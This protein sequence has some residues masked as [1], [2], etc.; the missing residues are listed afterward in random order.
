MVKLSVILPVFNEEK[1]I[2]LLYDRLKN[3]MTTMQADYEFIFINDGSSDN[4]LQHVKSLSEKD[5]AVKYIDFSRNF[6]HQVAVTAG[7]HFAAGQRTVIIDAD[8]QDPP[9]LIAEMNAKMNDGWNVVYAKRK[10]RKGES[11]FK[12]ITAML[13]YRL[14]SK[15]TS[16][17]IPVDTG[18]FRMIDR[19]VV[20][21]LNQ[22]PEHHKFIRGMVSWIGFKQTYVEYDRDQ[23]YAG[24]TGYTFRKMFRFALDGITGF[25][26]LP[27]KLATYAGFF[28]SA[29]S[30]LM[31]LYTLYAKFISEDYVQGWASI[32][33]SILFIGGIQLICLGLIGEYLIRMDAN[34]RQRPLYIIHDTNI[35]R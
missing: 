6:G 5:R 28:F 33:I 27:L 14:L 16:I 13:F 15:L 10:E 18:D 30:F 26:N 22:M 17:E 1:N 23:R 21:A 29:V 11:F 19:R 20:D 31:I 8:L 3:V 32:M 2:P 9:E 34:I 35:E 7:L 24:K 12:K 4:T 25:S